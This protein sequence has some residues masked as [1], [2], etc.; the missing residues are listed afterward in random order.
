[1]NTPEA[2]LTAYERALATQEW[3][4]VAPLI[5]DDCVVTFSEG[6]HTGKAA[7]ERAFRRTFS[8][9]Q[10]ERFQIS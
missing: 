6:T 9:I 2:F 5:H 4:N 8:T 3:E 10:N 7:V 1:M